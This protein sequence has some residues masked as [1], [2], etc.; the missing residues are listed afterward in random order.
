MDNALLILAL[1][2]CFFTHPWIPLPDAGR[3]LSGA[4]ITFQEHMKDLY[5][6]NCL[7]L[8]EKKNVVGDST[9]IA[10]LARASHSKE[11]GKSFTE[12]EVYGNMFV[13]S[14]AGHDNTAHLITFAMY[15][16]PLPHFQSSRS[17]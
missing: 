12:S 16:F 8:S 10:S 2:P 5:K 15:V 17:P 9:M 14:F 4:C 7:S 6:R 3:K 13:A 11:E 1:R